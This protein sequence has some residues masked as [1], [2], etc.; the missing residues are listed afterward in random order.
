MITSH[1]SFA[2]AE[3]I[4]KKELPGRTLDF[5]VDLKHVGIIGRKYVNTDVHGPMEKVAPGPSSPMKRGVGVN[6]D[7]VFRKPQNS[8]VMSLENHKI[9]RLCIST[10]KLIVK[11]KCLI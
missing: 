5:T 3:I 4:T 9:L 11:T 7:S 8:Q 1:T 6:D 2:E 10:K